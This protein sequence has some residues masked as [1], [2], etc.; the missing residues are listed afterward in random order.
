MT[1]IDPDD[2]K[3]TAYVLG[4]LEDAERAAVEMELE[5]SE[6]ARML[7]EELRFAADLTKMELREQVAVVPLTPQARQ[8]IRAAAVTAENRAL[9]GAFLRRSSSRSAKKGSVGFGCGKRSNQT[10]LGV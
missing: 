7:V 8:T 5:S 3:W 6:E 9:H 4:E 10:R 1:R 2:P